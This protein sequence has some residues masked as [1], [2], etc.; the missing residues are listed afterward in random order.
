MQ[1]VLQDG[2]RNSEKKACNDS[3]SCSR[4]ESKKECEGEMIG[5]RFTGAKHFRNADDACAGPRRQKRPKRR[6][7]DGAQLVW[8][9]RYLYLGGGDAARNK[10]G[11]A[12]YLT[13]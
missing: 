5:E 7:R 12:T 3:V 4:C 11:G 13:T 8:N 2:E 9:D 10:R 6:F 1:I